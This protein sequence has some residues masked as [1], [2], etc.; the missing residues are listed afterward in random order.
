M[1]GKSDIVQR[2]AKLRLVNHI[3]RYGDCGVNRTLAIA[4]DG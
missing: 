2:S 4:A 3:N 1:I